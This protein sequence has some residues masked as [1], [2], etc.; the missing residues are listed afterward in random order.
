MKDKEQMDQGALLKNICTT[1][2]IFVAATILAVTF[3]HYS[4]NSTSVAII[5]VLAVMLIARYTSGYVPGIVASFIGVICVNYVFTYP[6]MRLNF[7]IDGYPVT[8]VSMAVISG[9]TSALTTKFKKQNQILNERE[10][11]LMEAEKETMRANLLRAVSHDLR[12]PLTSIIGMA[13]SYLAGI[14]RLTESE[15]SYMVKSIS[16]DA[17]WLLNMVENLLSVTRIRVGETRVNTTPEPLEEVVSEAVMRL[18]KRLPQANKIQVQVPENFL[19][20]PMDAVL[21]EQVIINLLENA[22]YHSGAD[23]IELY[24]IQQEDK[25]EF[26][27]RDYGKGIAPERLTVIFDGAGMESNQSGDSHRGMGI[28]L[29][30]C[31]TI[32]NAH[33]GTIYGRNWAQGAEFIFTLPLGEDKS[34][35][36]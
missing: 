20:V 32:I 2:G 17:N 3:F 35:G 6:F 15:K 12:T 16:E 7:S 10:K 31:K 24:V 33:Q 27:I 4:A 26:H 8:F 11:L 30:I 5:Y 23:D 9:L 34:N 21:I 13:D 1:I 36:K 25:V 14:D 29:T 19:M 18:K 22:V 28:G